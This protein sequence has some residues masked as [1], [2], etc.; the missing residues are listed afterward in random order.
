MSRNAPPKKRLLTSEQHSFHEISQS[1][2]PFHFQERFLAK[3]ALWNLSNQSMSFIFVSRRGRCH[4]WTDRFPAFVWGRRKI[5]ATLEP[6][7]YVAEDSSR[8]K[9]IIRNFQL[10]NLLSRRKIPGNQALSF[11]LFSSVMI[12]ACEHRLFLATCGVKQKPEIPRMFAPQ[13]FSRK[14]LRH[15]HFAIM[16]LVCSTERKQTTN[17]KGKE[18]GSDVGSRLFGDF[19]EV[20]C[21]IPKNSCWGN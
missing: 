8:F 19:G 3:F 13:T 14:S 4:K 9:L 21:D 17:T 7:F 18:C 16:W 1:P 10:K 20:L 15:S 6:A 2:L 12:V 11:T 5:P